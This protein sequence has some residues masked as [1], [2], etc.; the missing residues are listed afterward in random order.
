MHTH[1]ST[2]A[3]RSTLPLLP[4]CLAAVGSGF[5]APEVIGD[6]Q[7]GDALKFLEMRLRLKNSSV[8]VDDSAWAKVY[9]VQHP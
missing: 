5:W 4:T 1:R 8:I 3:H 6:F 7:E 9:K 2:L